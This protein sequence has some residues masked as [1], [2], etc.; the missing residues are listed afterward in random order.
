MSLSKE[1]E[2]IQNTY[3]ADIV[4]FVHDVLKF[5]KLDPWQVDALNSFMDT[6]RISI[7]GGT[8]LGKGMVIAMC[9]LWYFCLK[10]NAKVIITST[11]SSTLSSRTF[12]DLRAIAKGSSIAHWFDYLA[13]ELRFVGQSG[14]NTSFIKAITGN[15]YEPESLRGFHERS[16]G[17]VCQIVD[18]ASYLPDNLYQSLT[19]N[20]THENNRWLMISNPTKITGPFYNTFKSPSWTCYNVSCLESSFVSKEYCDSIREEYGEDSDVY[21]SKVLGQFPKHSFES[22]VPLEWLQICNKAR[23]D[24]KVWKK[25][26]KVL[27]IDVAL[28]GEDYSV[29][30]VRQGPKIHKFIK[31]QIPDSND[32]EAEIVR[33]FNTE[34]ADLIVIDANGLGQPIRDHLKKLIDPNK[35]I[36]V[37]GQSAKSVNTLRWANKRNELYFNM[38]DKIREEIEIPFNEDLQTELLNIETFIDIKNRPCIESKTRMKSRGLPSPDHSDALALALSVEADVNFHSK[39]S[40][41]N[42]KY[43]NKIVYKGRVLSSWMGR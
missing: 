11:N 34:K 31:L 41:P 36:S 30:C 12:F 9:A 15:K 25:Y 16:F 42:S 32:L 27:G 4:G 19:G 20:I 24:E 10:P 40:E 22:F 43:A 13:T 8:G 21:L 29:I 38:R 33:I 35:I 6:Q 37:L 18:E 2:F 39:I 3:H 23:I 14:D 17:H 26:P 1:V 28:S 7:A 5:E